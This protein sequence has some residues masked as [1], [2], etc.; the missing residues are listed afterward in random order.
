MDFRRWINYFKHNTKHFEHIEWN[1]EDRLNDQEYKLIANSI[2]QFQLGE[3]SEGKHLMNFAIEFDK[4]RYDDSYQQAIKLFIR[5]EQRHAIVLGRFMDKHQIPKKKKDKIDNYFRLIRKC[6][7]HYH[8]IMVLSTAEIIAAVYY[9][10]LSH[11][12]TS[13]LLQQI[14]TQINTDE[15]QHLNFQAFTL[16]ELNTSKSK[17]TRLLYQF[18]HGLFTTLTAQV[19]W[20]QHYK[21]LKK[22]GHGFW[23]FNKAVFRQFLNIYDRVSI[24][25]MEA[26]MQKM[27]RKLLNRLQYDPRPLV[28]QNMY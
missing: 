3:H 18:Y 23:S 15:E 19:V 4:Q 9:P 25:E 12:T 28:P 22:G 21:L 26:N 24:Y 6:L 14:C 1:G 27:K 8:S 13:K 20:W 11:A 16:Q 10:A 5:E 17:I 2:A 7:N